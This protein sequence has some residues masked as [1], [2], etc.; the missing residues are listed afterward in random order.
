MS[1]LPRQA[2]FHSIPP[3]VI[4]T[5]T[6]CFTKPLTLPRIKLHNPMIR[7]RTNTTQINQSSV[8][9]PCKASQT[10]QHVVLIITQQ[11]HAD[12]NKSCKKW[13]Q[14]PLY[15]FSVSHQQ[16]LTIFHISERKVSG[17]QHK[18][19]HLHCPDQILQNVMIPV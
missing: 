5:A 17:N 19:R 7:D 18:T 1:I 4:K 9:S 11:Q 13:K 14:I 2:E 15:A 10:S 6:N 8:H 16:L 3:T 12:Q